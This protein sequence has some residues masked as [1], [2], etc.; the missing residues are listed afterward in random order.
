MVR[1][2]VLSCI[3]GVKVS[4]LACPKPNPNLCF[5]CGL[6]EMLAVANFTFLIHMIP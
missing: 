1:E 3:A 4:V 2:V 6:L 5:A